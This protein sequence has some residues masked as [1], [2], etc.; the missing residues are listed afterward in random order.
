MLSII[1]LNYNRIRYSKKTI[2][3]LIKKTT[4]P[5]EFI[6]VDNGSVD[7]TRAY[8]KR[9]ERKTNAKQ[10]K[11]VFNPSNYGVAGGRNSGL[12]IAE[13]D[14]LMT[15]DDDIIVPDDYDKK[16]IEICDNIPNIGI[17]G[18][19][20]ERKGDRLPIATINDV[21]V[22]VKREGN[23]GGGCLCLP[24]HVF[25]KVGYYRPDFVYGG[26]DCDMY[27]RL[28]QL[29]LASL[30][31]E[32]LGEHIDKNLN[33]TY[34]N[35][36]KFSHSKKSAAYKKVGDNELTYRRTKSVYIPYKEPKIKTDHFDL[37]IKGSAPK[38]EGTE[39]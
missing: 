17:T 12:K 9:L 1:V 10:V 18:V 34:A 39:K 15:I 25:E 19:C 38:K 31:I 32:P 8:L 16:L 30:Y 29:K 23:L 5:H 11:W 24:R 33:K 4:V 22:R 20:V 35:L 14:Y 28:R 2:Q 36:K 7:G 6:F 37:V 3:N 27:I 21:R 26:E 13:G